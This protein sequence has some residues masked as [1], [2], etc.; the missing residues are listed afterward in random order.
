MEGSTTR[1]LA[2]LIAAAAIVAGIVAAPASA[3]RHPVKCHKMAY[4]EVFHVRVR[5]LDPHRYNVCGI[6]RDVVNR[7]SFR[8]DHHFRVDGWRWNCRTPD[9]PGPGPR[10]RRESCKAAGHR[11]LVKWKWKF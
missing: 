10:G 6:A 9:G 2:V 7:A 8:N 4:G 5:G 11:I 1:Y 3:N